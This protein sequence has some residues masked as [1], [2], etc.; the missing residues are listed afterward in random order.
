LKQAPQQWYKRLRNFLLSKG[1][2]KDV[3]DKTLFICK[4]ER[5][6]ILVQV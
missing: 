4:H 3:V 5:D 2:A 1:Y 6:V